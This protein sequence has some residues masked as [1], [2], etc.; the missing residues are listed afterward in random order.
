MK[1][2]SVANEGR[3]CITHPDHGPSLI[4]R[5]GAEWCPHQAHD[6][7]VRSKGIKEV[8]PTTPWLAKQVIEDDR[9]DRPLSA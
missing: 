8:K 9:T 6:G 4:M 7:R 2:Q 3:V 5:S 1:R